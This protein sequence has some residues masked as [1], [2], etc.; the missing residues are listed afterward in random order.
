[1][2]NEQEQRRSRLY[3][4]VHHYFL[5]D[6][7]WV[8]GVIEARTGDKVSVRTIQAWLIEPS[9]RSSRNCP[10]GA[11]K[12]LEEYIQDPSNQE[13]L[14]YRKEQH[15]NSFR[16]SKSPFAWSNEVRAIRSVEFATSELEEDERNLAKYQKEFGDRQGLVIFE[17]QKELRNSTWGHAETLATIFRAV[18]ESK[19]FDEFRDKFMEQERAHA[20]KRFV[21]REAKQAIENNSEEFG[22]R[23]AV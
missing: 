7:D 3:S 13:T 21:V 16:A 19:T 11:I 18:Q 9:R 22:D 15:Q 23:E 6:T 20:I 10:E 14:Q 4:L 1:M 5:A 12:A 8:A 17:L 2:K